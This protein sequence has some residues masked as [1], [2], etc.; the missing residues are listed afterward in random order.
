[1][2]QFEFR[3][4]A[5]FGRSSRERKNCSAEMKAKGAGDV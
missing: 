4:F 2:G 5:R 1:V 3:Y